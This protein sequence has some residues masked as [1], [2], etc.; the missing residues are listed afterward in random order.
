[1]L[2]RKKEENKMAGY[3]KEF[4]K[5]VRNTI[6][7]SFYRN[8]D[9]VR[10]EKNYYGYNIKITKLN[11]LNTLNG[12]YNIV[13]IN[14][15]IEIH[16]V[17]VTKGAE[18]FE[19]H[20]MLIL[21]PFFGI[22]AVIEKMDKIDFTSKIFDTTVDT[23]FD[24]CESE[25][26][27]IYTFDKNGN[28]ICVIRY[29]D[30]YMYIVLNKLNNGFY[31]DSYYIR[32]GNLLISVSHSDF[33]NIVNAIRRST[34]LCKNDTA[35]MK[36]YIDMVY[37]FVQY[38]RYDGY[39]MRDEFKDVLQYFISDED[40]KELISDIIKCV[41]GNVRRR[42]M[43]YTSCYPLDNFT[44]FNDGMTRERDM[45]FREYVKQNCNVNIFDEYNNNDSFTRYDYDGGVVFKRD[46]EEEL[47]FETE[48]G[49]M[50]YIEFNQVF[51][52]CD[53]IDKVYSIKNEHKNKMALRQKLCGREF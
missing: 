33:M 30:N 21:H 40:K 29:Q 18:V 31:R 6:L 35:F 14:N 22:K 52:E 41:G 3:N 11:A 5:L 25:E 42:R 37:T 44:I 26:G 51:R 24:G 12:I 17:S 47:F 2:Y 38:I 8:R 43:V 28:R 27:K 4:E 19:N 32:K 9:G 53:C 45:L 36:E 39:G 23:R 10:H 13:D 50:R 49:Y 16:D 46:D 48:F 20:M 34:F 15:N 1:M 7:D